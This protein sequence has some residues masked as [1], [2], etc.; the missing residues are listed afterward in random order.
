[1]GQV[2]LPLSLLLLMCLLASSAS[3]MEV[4]GKHVA[5]RSR[6]WENSGP[7]LPSEVL[8]YSTQTS[9]FAAP[10]RSITGQVKK[11]DFRLILELDKYMLNSVS[12]SYEDNL[13]LFG[14]R[15]IFGHLIQ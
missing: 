8:L 13:I 14:K 11:T 5:I 10:F 9:L 15:L 12:V 1:M 7:V 3:G 6:Y 4:E 2:M